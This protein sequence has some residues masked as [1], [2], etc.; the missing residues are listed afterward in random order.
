MM[1]MI[2]TIFERDLIEGAPNKFHLPLLHYMGDE[3][4]L[5]NIIK[6]SA[7]QTEYQSKDYRT[8]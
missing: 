3:Y 1:M 8:L 7:V 5:Y 2:F 6:Y 4:Y